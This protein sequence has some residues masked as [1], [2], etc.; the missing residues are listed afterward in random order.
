MAPL[1]SNLGAASVGPA[2]MAMV[3]DDVTRELVR[4]A[5]HR[6]GLPPQHVRVGGL[7][8]ARGAIEAS[9]APAI[10]LI[11]ASDTAEVLPAIDRLGEVC[12]AH[13][14]VVVI[15]A[16]NDIGLYRGLMQLGVSDYLVKP[17]SAEALAEA[18]GRAAN[19]ELPGGP[20]G[21]RTARSLALIGARGG[22]GTTSLAV[23]LACGFARERQRRTVLLDLDLQFGTAALGL[24]L[25]PGRGLAELLAHP[26]R[27][28]SLLVGSAATQAGDRLRVLAAE[29]LLAGPLEVQAGAL[30]ALV[31][32]LE[33]GADEI[34]L[35][36]PR[37]LDDLTCAALVGADVVGVVTDL[38][39]AGLRD[40]QRL[41]DLLARLRAG[42]EVLLLGNRVGAPG[43]APRADFEKA[44]GRTLDAAVPLDAKAAV[45]AAEQGAS[46]LAAKAGPA[47]AELRRLLDR[48][49]GAGEAAKPASS[50]WLGRILGAARHV[51]A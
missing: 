24:D 44:L 40:S 33:P 36:L 35:D 20:G 15:G 46:L 37:R 22:V 3:C 31:Q 1:H 48:L 41:L 18:L 50:D 47:A 42:G 43:E 16:V 11:D 49:C 21:G 27:I 6:L 32:S 10:L 30:E 14:R 8:S 4:Q 38:S 29:E 7:A 51:R 19:E 45:A 12:E 2:F 34:V 5:A 25:E 13:T 28:D 17:I 23:A 26:D 39:L 9:G